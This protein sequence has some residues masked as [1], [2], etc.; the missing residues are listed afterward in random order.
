M[1]DALVLVGAVMRG[2]FG[3]GAIS[4]LTEPGASRLGMNVTRIVAASSGAVNG[5]YYAAA[6]RSGAEAGA[7]QRLARFWVEEGTLSRVVDLSARNLVARRGLAAE[8]KVLDLL[9]RHIPPSPTLRGI[10]LRLVVTN[11]DG[12]RILVAGGPA[13]TFE[14]VV[15]LTADDFATRE[16]LE[17]VF[18]G[19][20]ASAAM[21]M[22]FA[23]VPLETG[24]RTVQALDGGLMNQSPLR[25]ALAGAPEISRVLV[26]SPL[27][28]VR[29]RPPRLRGHSLLSEVFDMLASERI[30]RDLDEVERANH[31]LERIADWAPDL[32]RRRLLLDALG[33][34]DRRPVRVV[35]IRPLVELPGDAFSALWSRRL[36]ERY[37]LAGQEAARR[38]IAGA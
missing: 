15:E 16:G 23:P 25:L 9:R 18:A 5:A 34:V 7:G 35:E 17:R 3:A 12:E 2:A 4:V 33:L 22:L 1:S 11:A 21:P 13:T 28:R 14:H 36:R 26:V 29:V 24:G 37:V 27:P 10:D 32:D 6:I 38:A 30:L 31:L 20:A 19:V 8:T